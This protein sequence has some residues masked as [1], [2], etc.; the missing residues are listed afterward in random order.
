MGINGLIVYLNKKV[1]EVIRPLG[2]LDSLGGK[3]LFIDC[4]MILR[5][6]LHAS[7]RTVLERLKF[8]HSGGNEPF[9]NVKLLRDDIM[10]YSVNPL[11]V[12]NKS[13]KE[14]DVK[15]GIDSTFVV[16]PLENNETNSKVKDALY[17]NILDVKDKELL[18]R[19]REYLKGS[20][21]YTF[22][23]LLSHTDINDIANTLMNNYAKKCVE[24]CD[25]GEDFVLSDD[26][27]A[28]AYGAPNVIRDYLGSKEPSVINH[29]EMLNALKMTRDQFIDFCILLGYK[30]NVR[31][32]E[33][34]PE[35]TYNIIKRY[36]SLEKF[37]ESD[38]YQQLFKTKKATDLLLKYGMELG[39]FTNKFFNP[40]FRQE[41]IKNVN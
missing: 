6:S 33:I 9:V 29:M 16:G 22:Y 11:L 18:R 2:S 39:E 26:T 7:I 5:R 32:P 14:V 34:G 37:L 41:L 30:A 17:T 28:I 40:E 35:R 10:K 13:L 1:P 19:I 15:G 4:S 36:K 8:S 20:T 23:P 24:F 31:I 12:L 38:L 3:R 25:S 21:I 27:N